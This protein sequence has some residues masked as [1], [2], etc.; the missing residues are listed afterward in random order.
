MH[1]T[2]T[3]STA[4]TAAAYFLPLDLA[5][6][7]P[8]WSVEMLYKY[9]EKYTKRNMAAGLGLLVASQLLNVLGFL[10]VAMLTTFPLACA[11]GVIGGL[12]LGAAT[13]E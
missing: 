8:A 4:L 13:K 11:F 2:N 6:P 5:K 10:E 12:M 3:H 9:A 7:K 1:R